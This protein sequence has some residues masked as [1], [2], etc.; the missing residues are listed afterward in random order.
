MPFSENNEIDDPWNVGPNDYWA[1]SFLFDDLYFFTALECNEV[2]MS[3]AK[4]V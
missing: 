4:K 2:G 3:S 1:R